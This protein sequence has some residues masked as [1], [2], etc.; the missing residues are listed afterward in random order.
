MWENPRPVTRSLVSETLR[1]LRPHQWAKNLLVFVP[2]VL[3]PPQV[4]DPDKQLKAVFAFVCLCL[5]ASAGYVV[6]DLLDLAADR[7]HPVK[8]NRPFASGALPVA[9]GLVLAALLGAAGFALAVATTPSGFTGL[10]GLYLVT[11]L[12]YSLFLKRQLLVD[13]FV[14]AGLYTLRVIAGALAIAIELTPWLLAFSLFIFL[15]LAFAKRYSELQL[16][17]TRSETHARG[18]AY[19]VGDLELVVAPHDPSEIDAVALQK[20]KRD[21]GETVVS[22]AAMHRDVGARAPGRQRLVRPLAARKRPVVGRQNGLSRPRQRRHLDD[23]V[24]V[25]RAEYDDHRRPL[26]PN[27]CRW[28]LRQG[29]YSGDNR[30]RISV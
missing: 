7:A 16:M 11:T 4:G 3:T 28:R 2:L 23:Q 12:A 29:L 19:Q 6:N 27:G 20:P 1:A 22:D 30:L 17:A 14:L 15:S 21:V 24:R 18:R 5:V 8:R 13:V 25:D 26:R 9:W 10:L